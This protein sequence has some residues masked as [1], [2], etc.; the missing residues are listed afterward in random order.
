MAGADLEQVKVLA[1]ARGYKVNAWQGGLLLIN[2]ET[3]QPESPPDAGLAF[4]LEEARSFLLGVAIASRV[5]E[6]PSQKLL[7]LLAEGER[8]IANQK[9]VIARLRRGN[10]HHLMEVAQQLL[11]SFEETQKNYRRLLRRAS[12]RQG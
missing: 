3:R 12:H 1:G 7:R 5:A 9:R 4:S 8:R 6:S 2:L 10:H 11:L